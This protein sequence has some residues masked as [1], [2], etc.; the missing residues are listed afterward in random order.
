MTQGNGGWGSP[1]RVV[2]ITN[3]NTGDA[4][5]SDFV[6]H[7]CWSDNYTYM[8]ANETSTWINAKFPLGSAIRV[9]YKDTSGLPPDQQGALT[10]VHGQ[11]DEFD[12][13][14]PY[15]YSKS[16]LR[17]GLTNA[18]RDGTV[19]TTNFM[20]YLRNEEVYYSR[21]FMVTDVLSNMEQV[22]N[23]LKTEAYEEV[24]SAGARGSGESITLYTSDG[25]LFFG[26]GIGTEACPETIVVCQGNSSPTSQTPRPLFYIQCGSNTVVTHD[27]YTDPYSGSV[28]SDNGFKRPYQCQLDEFD[29]TKTGRASWKLLGF[30]ADDACASLEQHSTYV[31]DYCEQRTPS[32]SPS[33]VSSDIPSVV[34]SSSPSKVASSIPTV[35][36]SNTPTITASLSP[37]KVTSSTPT[38]TASDIPTITSSISPSKVAS[39]TPSITA[40]DIPTI[41]SSIS[42]SQAELCGTNPASTP[43]NGICEAGEDCTNSPNDCYGELDGKPQR[44]FCC[45]G[46]SSSLVAYGTLCTD[47]RCSSSSSSSSSGC[48][49]SNDPVTWCCGDGVCAGGGETSNNCPQD[50]STNNPVTTPAPTVVVTTA[51]PTL[52]SPVVTTAAPTPPTGGCFGRNAWCSSNGE[53]CSGNCKNNGKCA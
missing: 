7:Y 37:S 3:E 12:G 49:L 4:F 41:T 28:P 51:A 52:S 38:I 14:L 9:A 26:A 22:G 31:S 20:G 21:K 42:P 10:F 5:E 11:N 16:R 33:M 34:S 46:G 6:I 13:S 27:P 53:C 17:F 29:T 25:S 15:Y 45:H 36:A 48:N 39:S 40:S 47:S 44:R 19:F 30:F 24:V 1:G 23:D 2:V 43:N 8:S 18:N 50:C 32:A 35:T